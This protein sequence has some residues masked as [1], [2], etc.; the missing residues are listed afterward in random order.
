MNDP[1]D[2]SAYKPGDKRKPKSK[3]KTHPRP[4]LVKKVK[5]SKLQ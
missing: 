3:Q 2:N 1:A 4:V 5:R